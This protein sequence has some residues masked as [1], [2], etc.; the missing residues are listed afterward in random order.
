MKKILIF[1]ACLSILFSCTEK[2]QNKPLCDGRIAVDKL[3]PISVQAEENA[4]E[5]LDDF[6]HAVS[7]VKLAD[8]PLLASVEGIQIYDDRI[9]IWDA[10]AKIVCYDMH[11]NTLFQIDAHGNGPNEYTNINAFTIN[12]ESKEI[13][14][15]DN[16]KQSL[17][18]YSAENGKPLRTVKF[19]KPNPT[20]MIF[21]DGVFFYNN[22]YHRNYPNDT[23][24][25]YSLLS[26]MDGINMERRYFPHN[27]VEEDYIF[28][29]SSYTFYNNDSVC[30][31]CR[32][33]DNV[34]YQLGRDSLT[35]CYRIDLPDPLPTAKVEEKTDPYELV[36]SD[37]SLGITNVYECGG[38][39]YFRFS[40]GGY[41]MAALYDLVADKQIC[42]T[43]RMLAIPTSRLPLFD[44]IDGVYNG[45]FFGVLTPAFI[46]Y[47]VSKCPDDYPQL[48]LDYD[49]Q[50]DNPII[51]F[52]KV[53][54]RKI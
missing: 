7:F 19:E 25:H 41:I 9:F 20:E 39:L 31:Y 34:I 3:R 47:M 54:R 5:H 22:R 8:T 4:F 27:D 35:A 43:K 11:G 44:V 28:S 15:Y 12:P 10:M 49:P 24:L 23:L 2:H 18:Y 1:V 48:F 52:Y 29:P 32:N 38:L 36:K 45:C 21:T 26:S 51:A 42:C 33:F 14:I 30:Y 16:M 50:S 17:I 46:D 6:L 13:V 53:D 40:K 37:Y